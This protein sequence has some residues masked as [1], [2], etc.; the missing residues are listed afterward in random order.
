MIEK[1]K[2]IWILVPMQA[3]ESKRKFETFV[4]ERSGKECHVPTHYKDGLVMLLVSPELDK[5]STIGITCAHMADIKLR[6]VDEFVEKYDDIKR[7]YDIAKQLKEYNFQKN[8]ADDKSETNS[9]RGFFNRKPK[10]RTGHFCLILPDGNMYGLSVYEG[11]HA[12]EKIKSFEKG[13]FEVTSEHPVLFGHNVLRGEKCP[14]CGGIIHYK[15]AEN[16]TYTW[17][18]GCHDRHLKRRINNNFICLT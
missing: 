2:K 8:E 13:W 17:C 6:G 9:P 1:E 7:S 4:A 11:E 10:K 12:I 14:K 18:I 5:F 16:G 3:E 15:E